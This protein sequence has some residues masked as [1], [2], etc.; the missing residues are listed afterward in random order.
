MTIF[1][2]SMKSM[3]LYAWI[4]LT[5]CRKH[6]HQ[7]YKSSRPYCKNCRAPWMIAPDYEA[8]AWERDHR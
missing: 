6:G 4:R 1:N 8:R 2:V 3:P 5:Y 7:R